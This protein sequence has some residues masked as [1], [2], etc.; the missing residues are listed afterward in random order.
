MPSEQEIQYHRTFLSL[1]WCER[2]FNDSWRYQNDPDTLRRSQENLIGSNPVLKSHVHSCPKYPQTA[3]G[4]DPQ[5]RPYQAQLTQDGKK[6]EPLKI[7]P[8]RGQKFAYAATPWELAYSVLGPGSGFNPVVNPW[9]EVTGHYANVSGTDLIYPEK[10]HFENV[11]DYLTN[12]VPI[13]VR[14]AAPPD[15]WAQFTQYKG[16]IDVLVLP[17]GTVIGAKGYPFGSNNGQAIPVMSPLDFWTPGAGLAARAIRA[18]TDRLG[19]AVRE[20][21]QFLRGP[22]KELAESS[23]KRLAGKTLTGMAVQTRGLLPTEVQ[24]FGRRTLVMGEDMAELRGIMAHSYSQPGLYDV[25]I[26]GDAK[27]F[28]IRVKTKP[29]GEQIWKD[30]SVSELANIIRPRLA[31]G[32]KIRLLACDVGSAGGPARQ[33]ANEL[34]R[35]VFA[36]NTSLPARPTAKYGRKTFVPLD[37]GK[38]YVFVPHRG[39]AALAGKGGKV[40]GNRVQGEINKK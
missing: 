10:I 14:T 2:V 6:F 30:V 37:G 12:E 13:Y 7:I 24:H 26:H 31:P 19:R 38:F 17:N 32:D 25:I 20:G 34:N 33:L 1:H 29:N 28:L 27:T 9:M 15:G 21:F 40:T 22:T 16:G 5:A 35:T 3:P 11:G 23:A 18:I 36:P 4:L 39:D 8:K